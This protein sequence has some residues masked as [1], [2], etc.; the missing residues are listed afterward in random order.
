MTA[1]YLK[2]L[3]NEIWKPREHDSYYIETGSSYE[4]YEARYVPVSGTF[5]AYKYPVLAEH[6]PRYDF[7]RCRYCDRL[8]SQWDAECDGCGAIL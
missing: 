2:P 1:N 6:E 3:A 5:D 4:A 7:R 8:N